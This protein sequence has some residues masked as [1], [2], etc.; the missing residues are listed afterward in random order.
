MRRLGDQARMGDHL[1]EAEVLTRTLGDQHR[2]GRIVN[3]MVIRDQHGLRGRDQCAAIPT[4][5]SHL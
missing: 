2:L 5:E 1:H 3:F 4:L